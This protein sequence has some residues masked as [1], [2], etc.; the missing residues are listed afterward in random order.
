M[1]MVIKE[2]E[3][4]LILEVIERQLKQFE[5]LIRMKTY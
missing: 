1:V 4:D 5:H 2:V 3:I